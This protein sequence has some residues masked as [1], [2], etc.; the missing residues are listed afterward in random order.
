MADGN[1]KWHIA[2]KSTWKIRDLKTI[3][4]I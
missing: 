3:D 1:F 2:S 4:W